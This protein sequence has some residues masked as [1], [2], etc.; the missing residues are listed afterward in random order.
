MKVK[1]FCKSKSKSKSNSSNNQNNVLQ[2][3]QQVNRVGK[4]LHKNI[5]GAFKIEFSPNMCDVYMLV[6]YQ[7]PRHKQI[8]GNNEEN[9]MKEMTL[10]LNITTYQNK[11]RVNII[12]VS[13]NE[14]TLGHK[15]YLPEKLMNLNEAR[16]AILND[17]I[18]Y[19]NKE[20]KEYDFLF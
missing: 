4:Y 13:P 18:K 9:S 14:K 1:V 7:I 17:V 16:H 3:G 12:E 2:A 20:Y 19:L 6:L 5:D 11:L 10:N 8:P 15:T